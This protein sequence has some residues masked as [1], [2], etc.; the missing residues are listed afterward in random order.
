VGQISGLPRRP[1]TKREYLNQYEAY[2][3]RFHRLAA[4]LEEDKR[5]LTL[6]NG[7]IESSVSKEFIRMWPGDVAVD[8]TF[9]A[10]PSRPPISG[11]PSKDPDAGVYA[12]DSYVGWGYEA[13]IVLAANI[14]AQLP[15]VAVGMAV[16]RPGQDP[17]GHARQVLEHIVRRGHPT[18]YL[19][20]DR[21]YNNSKPET[22][23]LPVRLLGYEFAFDYRVDQLGYQE[24]HY[25]GIPQ[26]DG[27]WMCCETPDAL[28]SAELDYR[29][30]RIDEVTR[31]ALLAARERYVMVRKQR[32][33]NGQPDRFICPARAGRLRCP[34]YRTTVISDA[35]PV[36]PTGRS[37]HHAASCTQDSVSIPVEIG[38]KHAQHAILGPQQWA[39]LYKPLRSW[40]EGLNGVAKDRA[41]EGIGDAQRRRVRGL[42]P[43]SILIAC[44]IAAMNRRMQATISQRP[45]ARRSP[46]A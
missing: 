46:V 12:R 6:T 11:R 36:V 42:I 34:R 2:R 9:L 23:Q 25:R 39:R 16:H 26:V 1:R 29:Q 15:P 41:Y 8:A 40:I 19:A 21:A 37:N 30:G 38:A 18:R 32:G 17:G 5:L 7:I 43:Q 27:A 24:G 20:A 3:R 22:F 10:S 13:E 44:L 14:D 31:D 45:A 4:N 28:I 35:P 33:R